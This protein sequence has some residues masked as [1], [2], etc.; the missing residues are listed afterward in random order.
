MVDLPARIGIEDPRVP[1]DLDV[2][3][4]VSI[5]CSFLNPVVDVTKNQYSVNKFPLDSNN[6][7]LEYTYT[8]IYGKQVRMIQRCL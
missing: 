5:G 2:F 3:S 4:F 6:P 1:F 7:P 8:F